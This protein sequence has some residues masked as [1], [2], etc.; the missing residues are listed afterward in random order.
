MTESDTLSP[1][2]ST[3]GYTLVN[4]EDADQPD[5]SIVPTGARQEE[6][7]SLVCKPSPPSTRYF[8]EVCM[9]PDAFHARVMT[10]SPGATAFGP[11]RWLWK[12]K[13]G[14]HQSFCLMDNILNVNAL[15]LC[16]GRVSTV[17]QAPD[18][19]SQTT[20]SPL[21]NAV[22]CF[23]QSPTATFPVIAHGAAYYA[24]AAGVPP[25]YSVHCM[26]SDLLPKG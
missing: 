3:A 12:R 9:L 25:S 8:V 20:S 19:H 4:D 5:L 22:C 2:S 10:R 13:G 26:Q 11:V 14:R 7:C 16:S 23:E 18:G 6:G 21:A 24:S 17:T 15:D 1:L